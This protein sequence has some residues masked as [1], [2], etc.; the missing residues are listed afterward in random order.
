MNQVQ[1][2]IEC[3]FTLLLP[4]DLTHLDTEQQNFPLELLYP[5]GDM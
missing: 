3:T 2:L 4:L 5:K 1:D